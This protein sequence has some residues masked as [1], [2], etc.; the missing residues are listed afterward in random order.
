MTDTTQQ[1]YVLHKT[2]NTN[3][4]WFEFANFKRTNTPELTTYWAENN[5]YSDMVLRTAFHPKYLDEY[6][7]VLTIKR[8]NLP[9]GIV[10]TTLELTPKASGT[11]QINNTSYNVVADEPFLVDI[12][13]LIST[14]SGVITLDVTGP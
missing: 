2:Y 14:T 8:Y 11:V 5:E 9:G 13:D 6:K 3:N 12:Q 1:S 10:Q 7:S 4:S